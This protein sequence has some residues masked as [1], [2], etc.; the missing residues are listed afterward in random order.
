MKN[1]LLIIIDCLRYDYVTKGRMG[2]LHAWGEENTM[3]HNHW[4]TSHCTDPAITHMLSGKH[5]D[6]LRLYSMMY[7]KKD[8]SIPESVEM[9]SQVARPFGFETCF[10]TNLGR[11]YKR[12]VD[13]FVDCRGWNTGGIFGE[14]NEQTKKLRRPWFMVVHDDSMHA[15]YAGGSY[16]AAAARVD[17][18]VA[19][20]INRTQH[21]THIIVTSD[22]GEG[23]GQAGPDGREVKQHGYG[24]WPFLTHIPF[25]TNFP[26]WEAW[27]DISDH[28][29]TYSLL[30]AMLCELQPT[31]LGLVN[32]KSVFQAGATPKCFH[33]G[34]VFH[35]GRQF[36]RATRDGQ[37]EHY[38]IPEKEWEWTPDRK[39]ITMSMV[40]AAMTE[41][42]RSHGIDYG[43]S[44]DDEEAVIERLKGLGYW[45]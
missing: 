36:V 11:W 9:L 13:H 27:P 30:S 43:E 24:L 2:Y 40:T 42:C 23:L 35:D 16:A 28:Q 4:S 32:R 18:N 22:H 15:P 1:V 7:N 17:A 20:L 10:I 44:L 33:R 26:I 6:E 12:G 25:V 37:H 34:V 21:N 8:Y 39:W 3:F 31:G 41:H 29:T 19:T 14:A 45:E 5:P 38:Y